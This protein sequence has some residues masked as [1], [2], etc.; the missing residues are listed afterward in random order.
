[1]LST[2]PHLQLRKTSPNRTLPGR[3][4]QQRLGGPRRELSRA[5]A[6][7]P[8]GR[9]LMQG[10]TPRLPRSSRT[11]GHESTMTPSRAISTGFKK[12]KK[13]KARKKK[14]TWEGQ[15]RHS[16]AQKAFAAATGGSYQ[17]C[18]KPLPRCIKVYQICTKT[19]KACT[20]V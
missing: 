11:R 13:T 7:M 1:M 18:T 6:H 9:H 20:K 14:K 12:K 17:I 3:L 2:A 16:L 4:M 8:P 19:H 15:A 10:H 5:I